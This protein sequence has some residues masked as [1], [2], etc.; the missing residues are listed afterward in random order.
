[1]KPRLILCVRCT[2]VCNFDCSFCEFRKSN[3][4]DRAVLKGEIV[5][6]FASA[7]SD[8]LTES[9][10]EGLLVW[11]GGEPFAWPEI[12]S[13]TKQLKN[14]TSLSVSVVTNASSVARTILS[15]ERNLFD[16]ITVSIDGNAETHARM[17]RLSQ[18]ESSQIF[19]FVSYLGETKKYVLRISSIISRSNLAS[20]GDTWIDLA[21]RGVDEICFNW[22]YD[23]GD[24]QFF[25]R[26]HLDSNSWRE[27]R[28]KVENI[29]ASLREFRCRLVGS[30]RYFDRIEAKARKIPIPITYCSPGDQTIF[31][32]SNGD[33][34]P[35]AYTTKDFH[36]NITAIRTRDDFREMLNA[37]KGLRKQTMFLPCND[38]PETNIFG[39]FE[40]EDTK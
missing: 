14:T 12:I 33:A 25:E 20:I 29:R 4:V 5:Q 34:A 27:F 30:N 22:L 10:S 18:D 19:E 28:L 8:H 15:R 13:A 1:V 32:D 40:Y 31:I 16:E 37:W 6:R 2:D 36:T 17:R 24:R 39:K 9:H 26:E 3:E 23:N 7:V 38:C 35:C 21:R 11:I